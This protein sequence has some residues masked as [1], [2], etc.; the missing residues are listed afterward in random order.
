[1]K[2]PTQIEAYNGDME[3]LANDIGNLRYDAL[4]AFLGLLSEKMAEDGIND[5][6]ANRVKLARCLKSCSKRLKAAQLE[7]DHAQ[8]ICSPHQL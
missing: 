8:I 3:A 2:H 7:I 6:A 5:K 4:S 1:M